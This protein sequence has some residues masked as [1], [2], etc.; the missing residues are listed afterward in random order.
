ME[1]FNQAC[2]WIARRAVCERTDNPIQLQHLIS[3]EIRERFE[4][5]PQMTM[6]AISTACEGAV[7]SDQRILSW[8]A[9]DGVSLLTLNGPQVVLSRIGGYQ[10]ARR[11][12]IRGQADLILHPNLFSLYATR[13]GGPCR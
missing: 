1:H 11:D 5:N 7:T 10:K 2:S 9:P 3:G 6:R 13:P 4:L 12:R 8:K